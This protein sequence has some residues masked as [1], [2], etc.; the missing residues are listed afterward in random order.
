[1]YMPTRD[2]WEHPKQTP[3]TNI[4]YWYTDGSGYGGR[5]GAGIYQPTRNYR[6]SIPMGEWATVFQ[7]EVLGILK[8]AEYLN[9]NSA[10]GKTIYICTDSQAALGA[11]QKSHTESSVVWECMRALR[12][13]GESNKIILCW[14][15]GH[16]GIQGNE[17]AD[18][19]AKAGTLVDPESPPV[20]IP[21]AVGKLLI[22]EK[23][24]KAHLQRWR[25]LS[26]CRQAKMI[27]SESS[28]KLTKELLSME[29]EKL[30]TTIGLLTGHNG[31]R[32]H[33]ANL[34]L[35]DQRQCRLCGYEKEDS[36][37]V[38]C[39]CA[40]LAPKRFAI[41]GQE[42]ICPKD[43]LSQGAIS[44]TRLIQNTGFDL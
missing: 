3:S 19:L 37:H 44:L 28:L 23:M 9:N 6:E 25:N 33:Q 17:V 18:E 29:K 2:D 7:A 35:G 32:A 42:I 26:S 34:G 27:M 4:E 5:F 24:N 11:L 15:P 8:C 31:L 1:M 21:F 16:T 41:W 12:R 40:S 10:E 38:L 39:Q 13:L 14:V 30:R 20:G 22:K 43:L 36:I